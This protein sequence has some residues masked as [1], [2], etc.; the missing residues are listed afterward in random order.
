LNKLAQEK[1]V[2][3]PEAIESKRILIQLPMRLYMPLKMLVQYGYYP[4]IS[5]AVREAIRDLIDMHR[6]LGQ[7]RRR[8]MPRGAWNKGVSPYTERAYCSYCTKWIR[9]EDLLIENGRILCPH[10]RRRVRI[11]P[12]RKDTFFANGYTVQ[13]I[14]QK[15][16]RLKEENLKT[17]RDLNPGRGKSAGSSS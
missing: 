2:A 16:L 13:K 7:I 11:Q 5:E 6:D 1:Y 14:I 10:C 12:H 15:I 9:H 4:N 8:R 17:Y 3:L